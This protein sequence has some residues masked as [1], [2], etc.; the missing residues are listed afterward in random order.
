MK[1]KIIKLYML[2]GKQVADKSEEYDDIA[3]VAIEDSEHESD[4]YTEEEKVNIFISNIKPEKKLSS[5][6]ITLINTIQD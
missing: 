3:L 6:M 1:R 5:L 4:S 2:V